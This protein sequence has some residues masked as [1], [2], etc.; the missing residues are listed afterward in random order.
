MNAK[1]GNKAKQRRDRD[2]ISTLQNTP[3]DFPQATVDAMADES[4]EALIG[5]VVAVVQAAIRH[6]GAD[7]ERRNLLMRT[8]LADMAGAL[9]PIARMLNCTDEAPKYLPVELREVLGEAR[10]YP[11]PAATP[12]T[13]AKVPP[14][15]DTSRDDYDVERDPTVAAGTFDAP[16]AVERL[17]YSKPPLGY[18]VWLD[19]EWG[20]WCYSTWDDGAS[21][22]DEPIDSEEQAIAAA[23][24]H[25]KARHDPPGMLSSWVAALRR[26][27]GPEGR[28]CHIRP[29][30]WAYHDRRLA[31]W[32]KL[33]V[34]EGSERTFIADDLWPAILTWSDD[35][36]AEVERWLV[37][38]TA[39]MPEVL[40]AG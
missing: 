37:D 39:E 27:L 25:Y 22:N 6:G 21:F 28:G 36:V 13:V 18:V 26:Q 10:P 33:E 19:D 11:V 40:C 14:E 9:R 31:I 38:S 8:M 1:T 16:P 17:D 34:A 35:Q 15:Q 5:L 23:W 32:E 12:P 4:G 29:H 24:T 3:H 30:A 20:C 2:H 7:V